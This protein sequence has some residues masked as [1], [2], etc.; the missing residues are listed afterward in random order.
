LKESRDMANEA[1]QKV[2]EIIMKESPLGP[3]S[4][5]RLR[6]E[7]EAFYLR[8]GTEKDYTIEGVQA[9]SA[10]GFWI[11]A[12]GV[13][14]DY[15]TIF[16]HGGGF[17]IGSTK[18]HCDLCVKLS[19]ASCTTVLSVDYSLAPEHVFPA[20]VEDAVNSYLWLLDQKVDPSRIVISGISAGGTLTLSS[21]ISLRDKGIPLPRAGVCLSPAVDMTHKGQ[22]NTTNAGLDW[23]TKEGLHVLRDCY[24]PN[25][26]PMHPLASPTYA[27][28]AGLPPLFIQAGSHEMLFD[29][30]VNFVNKAKEAGVDVT[31]RD[32]EDMFHCWQIFS[33]LI[34]E[35][36][37][38]IDEAGTYIRG[39][40]DMSCGDGS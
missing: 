18:D 6:R 4:I 3:M 1:A 8:F 32:W 22:F 16:F 14:A 13:S 23:L 38:A 37:Q 9:G 27:D 25:M 36:Q 5:K 7:L 2:F 10:P 35:G 31:F 30:I 20:A 17:T 28:I 29:D 24:L 26:D 21:L 19:R 40:M 39:V 15:V 33:S 11:S 12:P 34:P